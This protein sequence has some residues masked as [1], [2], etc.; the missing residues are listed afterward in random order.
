MNVSKNENYYVDTDPAA[1][2]FIL[3]DTTQEAVRS[4]HN[5]FISLGNDKDYVHYIYN[6]DSGLGIVKVELG[7]KFTSTGVSEENEDIQDAMFDTLTSFH[8]GRYEIFWFD[9][10]YHGPA[11]TMSE[12][13]YLER[14]QVEITKDKVIIKEPIWTEEPV[15]GEEYLPLIEFPYLPL[16]NPS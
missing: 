12:H 8:N 7:D 3:E 14:H 11:G 16:G 9:M 6:P 2:L 5:C 13:P 1:F 15:E 4:I 10:M